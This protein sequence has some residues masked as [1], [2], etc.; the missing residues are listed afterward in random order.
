MITKIPP[1]KPIP[2]IINELNH[3]PIRNGDVYTY[4][5]GT[6]YWV[7][8]VSYGS[9]SLRGNFLINYIKVEERED[10]HFVPVLPIVTFTKE[11]EEFQGN[12]RMRSGSN[13]TLHI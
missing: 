13:S 8:G 2:E 12:M 6:L 1:K 7:T 9:G 3:L 10:F 4:T 11:I 5:D